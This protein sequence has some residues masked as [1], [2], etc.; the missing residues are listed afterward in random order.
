MASAEDGPHGGPYGGRRTSGRRVELADGDVD[1]LAGLGDLVAE[2]L[3]L[4]LELGRVHAEDL[5]E[6]R[7]LADVPLVGELV[8]RVL[9]LVGEVE[10]E[11]G[12]ALYRGERAEQGL[13]DRRGRV[14]FAADGLAGL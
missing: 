7:A 6:E 13:G 4:A 2:A 14:A 12:L 8:E 1:L 5:A 10:Q 9:D 11:L 3:V